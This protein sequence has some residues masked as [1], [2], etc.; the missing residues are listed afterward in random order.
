[1]TMNPADTKSRLTY[2][3]SGTWYALAADLAARRLF[4][5]GSDRRIH[6]IDLAREKQEPVISW[7]GHEN[8]V[9]ALELVDRPTGRVLV[10]A[11]Y[12]RSL[13]FW[14]PATGECA[15]TTQAH[16]GWVRDLAVSPDGS[17][18]V[19]AGDDMLLKIWETDSGNLVRSLAGHATRTP[20]GHV[21]ALYVVAF[22]PDGKHVAS[23]DRIGDVRVWEIET[24]DL[25]A[26]FQVPT[27][28][29]YDPRQ[30]K[31]SIG[32]IRSLA[33]S[34]DG[35]LLAVG[36]IGQIDNVDG[37]GGPAHVEIWD[38]RA[39]RKL[40]TLAAEGHKALVNDLVYHPEG[41]L[42]GAGGGSDTGLLAFWG[43]QWPEITPGSTG[44]APQKPAGDTKDRGGKPAEI[45][46]HRIKFDGHVH[47]LAL[48]APADE[49]YA[50]G[51][52]KLEVWSWKA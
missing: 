42:I 35:A 26:Q 22:T 9:S 1:M 49:L 20:Q 30:R 14:N 36:G 13:R 6:V 4:V 47:R 24:G 15:R 45:P 33:F 43:P 19:S 50:A 52:N 18:L 34:L 2:K 40:W 5:G 44:D 27:L 7:P 32:G 16:E 41:W 11:S 17:L 28:Y 29:T 51:Y 38:W 23:G 21:T 12:D 46:V 3:L 48:N 39:P 31:R 8:Y 37:L 10:S 25:A